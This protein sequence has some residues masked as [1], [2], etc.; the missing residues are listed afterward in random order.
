MPM[1][2]ALSVFTK[3]DSYMEDRLFWCQIKWQLGPSRGVL[4]LPKT[5]VPNILT[6][7]HGNLLTRHNRLFKT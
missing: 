5:I 7:I 6:K 1:Y 4:F 3:Q 2:K